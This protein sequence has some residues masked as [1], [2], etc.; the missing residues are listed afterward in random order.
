MKK[1][2][3]KYIIVLILSM[4]LVY[5]FK[6]EITILFNDLY[7]NF[8]QNFIQENR[9]L[10]ILKG[11]RATLIISISSILIGTLIGFLLFLLRKLNY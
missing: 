9:Y 2:K 1:N 3:I 11:L 7:N 8:S 10:L 6:D 5:Y 4:F